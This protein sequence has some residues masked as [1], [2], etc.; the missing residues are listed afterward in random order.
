MPILLTALS[1]FISA[2]IIWYT[3][4]STAQLSFFTFLPLIVLV[5]FTFIFFYVKAPLALISESEQHANRAIAE[6][7]QLEELQR[8]RLQIVFEQGK[9]PYEHLQVYNNPPSSER[10]FRV[11]VFN[12]GAKR[13][14][15]CKLELVEIDNYPNVHLP[16]TLKQWRDNPPSRIDGPYTILPEVRD[17]KHVFSLNG[18]DRQFFEF[19]D[20][21]EHDLHSEI[22]IRYAA[23][24]EVIRNR[25][26]EAPINF[27]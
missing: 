22:C 8:P 18:G 2:A 12:L 16:I 27:G 26:R 5:V 23:H 10:F 3:K 13:I 24:P 21:R 19:V 15:N 17:Y 20:L 7:A 25:Y 1:A 4:G 9:E 14:D 6:K 11:A